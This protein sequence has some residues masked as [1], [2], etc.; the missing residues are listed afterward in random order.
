MMRDEAKKT[1]QQFNSSATTAE[2]DALDC[3]SAFF[4]AIDPDNT[5]VVCFDGSGKAVKAYF[6]GQ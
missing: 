4:Y 1:I 6:G 2:L 3:E 5:L